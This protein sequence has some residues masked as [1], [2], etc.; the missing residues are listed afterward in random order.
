MGEMDLDNIDWSFSLRILPE[1]VKPTVHALLLLS[2]AAREEGPNKSVRR[3][4]CLGRRRRR[5]D[6]W[7]SSLFC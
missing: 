1:T 2:T 6:R 3:L 4:F 5:C 7:V